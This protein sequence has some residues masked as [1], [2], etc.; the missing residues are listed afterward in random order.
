M[1]GASGSTSRGSEDGSSSR[2]CSECGG[3]DMA[4]WYGQ[5]RS[6][7]FRVKDEEAFRLALG[8][9]DIE[10]YS[11]SDG[12]VCLLS[13]DEYGGWPSWIYGDEEDVEFDLAT[14]VSGHL[15]DGEVAVLIEV[16]AE[17]LR[18]LTGVAVAVNSRNEVRVIN[19]ESIYEVAKDLGANITVASY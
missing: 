8:E 11:D 12:R 5:A 10:V 3:T 18:Y 6:N 17:K 7:Y 9:V 14:V 2:K 15:C 4:D 1:P 19:L 13:E 16:G